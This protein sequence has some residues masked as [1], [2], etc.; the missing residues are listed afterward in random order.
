[1]SVEPWIPPRLR[2]EVPSTKD[3]TVAT[4]VPAPPEVKEVVPPGKLQR[5]LPLIMV[6]AIVGMLG[7]FLVSGVRRMTSPMMLLFPI[8][9]AFSALGM[10]GGNGGRGGPNTGEINGLRQQYLKML[11]KLRSTV[12]ARAN[13]Q[14][15]FL[16]HFAPPP[17]A[18][19]AM[20]GGIRMWE[21]NKPAKD[22]TYFLAA[23]VGVA[24]QKLGGGM[25]M[26]DAPP[27]SV[28]EP[29]C[30]GAA[31]R[32]FRAHRAVEGL[33]V[34]IDLK[35]HRSVQFFGDGDSAGLI[36]SMLLQLT[37]F[38]PP[39]LVLV[40]VVTDNP[41]Q[42]DWIKWLPHNQNPHRIDALGTERMV[43]RPGEAAAALKDVLAGRGDFSADA[44]YQ[45][46]K[47]TD[48]GRQPLPWLIVV[49]DRVAVPGCG[50][51]ME[52][53]TVLRRGGL[54]EDGLEAFGARVHIG[55][56]GSALKRRMSADDALTYWLSAVDCVD[57]PHA[58]QVARKMSR[59]RAA[60]DQQVVGARSGG[61]VEMERSWA[62]LH[63]VPDLG[64][65]GT[66]LWREHR[67]GDPDRM[68][69][70]IGW[71]RNGAPV[72][73]KIAEEAEQGMGSHGLIL[74]Y[75]GSGKSTFLVQVL[76][77][78]C[79]RFT[80]EE[81]NL[82]LIDYKGE[83]TFD[84]FEKLKH[85]VEI[86]SNLSSQDM[87]DR[88]SA[89]LRGEVERRQRLRSEMGMKTIGKKFR[90]ARQ[91]LK[92][93]ERGAKI[94][95]FP[96]LLVVTDEFT[97]LLKEHPEFKDD[98]E[99][100]ARQGRSD[101][102]CLMLAT[103]SLTGVSVGQLLSNCGWK[104]AMKT[105]SGTD[106]AAVIETKD[107]YHLEHP[108]EG[109]LKV[110][111]AEPRYFRGASVY[112]PYFPAT[113]QSG[114]AGKSQEGGG[115]NAVAPFSA[116]PV[117]V[118]GLN[119]DEEEH[120]PVEHT[121]EEIDN[122]PEVGSVV[123]TQLENKGP[124]IHKM[125]LPPLLR[126]RPVG[127]LVAASGLAV[128]DRAVLTLP[129][130]LLD[131]PY[132]HHQEVYAV[133]L[134]DANLAMLGRTR[135][136][137]SVAMQTLAVS[138]ASLNSPRQLQIYGLDFSADG[139]LL[140]LEGLPHVGGVAMRG[141]VDEI[142]RVIAEVEEVATKRKELFRASRIAGGMATYRNRLAEKT[143]EDDGLGDVLLL[144]DGFDAFKDDHDDLIPRIA[145]LVNNGLAVGIHVVVTVQVFSTLGRSLNQSFS[146]RIDFKLNSP[147]MSGV[148]NKKL[149]EAI[150]ADVPGRALDLSVGLHLM[151][152][153]PRLDDVAAV[154]DQGLVA[155]VATIA[156]RWKG[157]SARQVRV[158]PSR[159]AA[160]DLQ[161]AANS[162]H[163]RWTVPIGLYEKDL[164]AVP[165]DFLYDKHLNVFGGPKCGKTHLLAAMQ[166]YLTS[167]FTPEE[168][169]FVVVDFKGSKLLDGLDEDYLLRWT[170]KE[171]VANPDHDPR[172]VGSP[173]KILRD[174][175]RTGLVTNPSELAPVM[176]D[177][178][179]SMANR[180]LKGGESLE[181]RK[182][183]SWWDGPEIF[184]FVDDYAAVH[185]AAPGAFAPLAET[186]ANAPQV[187]MHSVV[188]CPMSIANRVLGAT[189][190][191]IK[192]NNDSGSANLV[193]DGLRNE[194]PVLSIRLERKTTGR[195]LLLSLDGQEVIQTPVVAALEDE[196]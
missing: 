155:A 53:V 105:A 142:K 120:A 182:A 69:T 134:T 185:S 81:L 72:M 70:P 77:G 104:I 107:A 86:I 144:L 118:P 42:W 43:Y 35:T 194:G 47:Q 136:G 119:E 114:P 147:E 161:L 8:M 131:V 58:R 121:A 20:V 32:F 188:S 25:Q 94:P 153:A 146:K 175:Q 11:T 66:S 78:L 111:G 163:S 173:A 116:T 127:E 56:D 117:P 193:M 27:E 128:G 176:L 84:G 61:V 189:N 14:Y 50:E 22:P 140:G 109:Y 36:R 102:I 149:A 17:S 45:G 137:K 37:V 187:G 44:Q 152:G 110:G 71:D 115:V 6:V 65:M 3:V 135:S 41:E 157:Q 15:K 179:A 82:V 21:R 75:T 30:R 96:T 167:R 38:H 184:I 166:G 28:I 125:W 97:A 23:R 19:A 73:L 130:G 113:G 1:M 29:V 141:N 154:D 2:A 174:V 49:A 87:I 164:S 93:R 59:W 171:A 129:I 48:E 170:G 90:D 108:G 60:T 40:A 7:I 24:R 57:E 159:V 172:Q 67:E 52:A 150:P 12:Y 80:P 132:Q 178:A 160:A 76:M 26:A 143:I 181:V 46:E 180:R 54:D 33:P 191:L 13:A 31:E 98:Y 10:L 151:I 177:M 4:D 91:Y 9:F 122:A 16:A 162:R 99:H 165:I 64:S 106:S 39:N 88:L 103:Q 148:G 190:S 34:V 196:Q 18:L 112:D 101:R 92:A 192:L 186:W 195:G 62:N 138:A 83:S 5:V 74:G 123:L 55:G 85:T 124:D 133:D 169:K 145:D 100:L 79:S 183:R 51:G 139:K 95:P 158:L 63:G 156:D 89:V 126:P 168:V 68:R